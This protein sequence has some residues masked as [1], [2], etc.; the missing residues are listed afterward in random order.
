[1]RAVQLEKKHGAKAGERQT[2]AV[3][4]IPLPSV[5][6]NMVLVKVLAAG[7]NRRDEWSAMGLYP[8]LVYKNATMGC[9]A[10]GILVDP[11]S[12]EPLENT[13]YLLTPMRGWEKDPAGPE[14]ALPGTSASAA[15]NEFGGCG[16]GLL[17]ATKQVVGAGTF[18]EYIAVDKSQL[19]PAP[20]HLSAVQCASLPCAVLTAFRALFTKG[21]VGKGANVLITG[22]GGG[23]AIFALQLAVAAGAHVFVT[24]GA[25]AKIEHAKRHGATG[26]ALY[27]DPEWPAQIRAM[28][29]KEHAWIDVVIDSA[30]G[31]IPAQSIRAGLRD[32]GRI[33]I[34]G[35]TAV[36]KTTIAMREVLKN[37]DVQGTYSRVTL[38]H[39]VYFGFR[40]RVS[41]ECTVCGT[42]QN[43]A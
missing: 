15:T 26:G 3:C 43:C 35:M 29:P 40:K 28:L 38:T 19:I 41:C 21:N 10:C 32:G 37:V 5:R 24:G 22:I 25:E 18:C 13:L 17:G 14:A 20:K 2:V 12:L 1:M 16:F 34:Y 6:E 8:G 42:A 9:D 11:H 39:R 23:V 36:P 7:L 33:V 30:G 31:D 27:R 4:D